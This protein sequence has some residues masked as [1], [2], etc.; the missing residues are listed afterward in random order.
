MIRPLRCWPHLGNDRLAGQPHA[1]DVD[2]HQLVHSAWAD[3]PEGLH[4]D[5]REDRR[6][7]DQDVETAELAHGRGGPSP[8]SS[9]HR[10]RRSARRWPGHLLPGTPRRPPF[11]S[12]RSSSATTTRGALL[13]EPMRVRASD[14]LAGASNDCDPILEL[15]V[16]APGAPRAQRAASSPRANHRRELAEGDVTRQV[17]H[18]ASRARE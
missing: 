2:G 13:D 5:G 11:P 8:D 1:A 4:R 7:V 9:S 16:A 10:R 17:F 14:S 15:I 6:V 18:S 12:P 3:L